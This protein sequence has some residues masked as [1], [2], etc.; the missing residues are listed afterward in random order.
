MDIFTI[1]DVYAID[2][3][4][5]YAFGENITS[6][7]KGTSYLVDPAFTIAGIAVTFYLLLGAFKYL[8]SAGDKNAVASAQAQIT[9]AIIGYILLIMLFVFMKFIPEFFG[10]GGLQII[11]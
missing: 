8:T 2:L 5:Q 11:K 10:F 1:K 6:L 7:A 9:H 4:T 3:K